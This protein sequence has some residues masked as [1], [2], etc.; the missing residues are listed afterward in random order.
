MILILLKI[1][2]MDGTHT[3]IKNL[4]LESYL[5]DNKNLRRKIFGVFYMSV[6]SVQFVTVKSHSLPSGH[7]TFSP[8]IN[9]KRATKNH[10][11]FISLVLYLSLS[12]LLSNFRPYS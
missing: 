11:I 2:E 6:G 1:I 12:F 3:L 10:P 5:P 8:F 9:P 4:T 7:L